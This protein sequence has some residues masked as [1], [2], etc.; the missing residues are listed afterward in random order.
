MKVGTAITKQEKYPKE[1][2]STILYTISVQ[3]FAFL[4]GTEIDYRLT[5]T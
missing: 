5:Y 4:G 1:I 3:K 2:K